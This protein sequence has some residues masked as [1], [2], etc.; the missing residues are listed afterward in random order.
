MILRFI[1][2]W[3]SRP[4]S[5]Y[6]TE[7]VYWTVRE[8]ILTGFPYMRNELNDETPFSI[9]KPRSRR[10]GGATLVPR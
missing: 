5:L 3:I 7:T 2:W 1:L 8:R 10:P 6:E 4:R 9:G